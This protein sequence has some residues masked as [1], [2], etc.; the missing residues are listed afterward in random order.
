MIL[1][2]VEKV[3]S[4]NIVNIVTMTKRNVVTHQAVLHARKFCFNVKDLLK[5]FRKEKQLT[6]KALLVSVFQ[7][8][9]SFVI[10]FPRETKLLCLL[11]FYSDTNTQYCINGK[12]SLV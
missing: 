5:S 9:S 1:L 6:F 3:P 8:L 4:C 11:P 10:L 2:G 12:K 7:W